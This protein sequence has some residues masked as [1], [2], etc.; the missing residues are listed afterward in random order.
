MVAEHHKLQS[1][2][3]FLS[4][5][6]LPHIN[7]K[8][9]ELLDMAMEFDYFLCHLSRL[10]EDGDQSDYPDNWGMTIYRTFYGPGSDQ[11]WERLLQI[12]TNGAYTGLNQSSYEDRMSPTEIARIWSF[13]KL[14]ARSNAP[15]LDGLTLEQVREVFCDGMGGQPVRVCNEE[16]LFILADEE[17]LAN[18]AIMKIVAAEYDLGKHVPR[19]G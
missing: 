15:L 9:R 16:R 2:K 7:L 14:D 19:G 13:F 6:F 3:S 4:L 12:I 11:Q 8:A 10:P 17:T 18:P 1:T 5:S